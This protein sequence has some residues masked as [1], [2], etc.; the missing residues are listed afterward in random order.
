[1][2]SHIAINNRFCSQKNHTEAFDYH[3]LVKSFYFQDY[4]DVD[5][6]DQYWAQLVSYL[7]SLHTAK[8][9]PIEQT[10]YGGTQTRGN[11]FDNE[12]P[13]LTTLLK[14]LRNIWADYC[15]HIRKVNNSF[16]YVGK[17][18]LQFTGSWSVALKSDGFHTAHIHPMGWIS[19]VIYIDLPEVITADDAK[20][21]WIYFGKPN[22]EPKDK[23][24][25]DHY[26]QPE[27]G[28]TVIFPSY[29]WHGTVP[30]KSDKHRLTIAYD[31]AFVESKS[32]QQ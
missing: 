4:L 21:G 31:A 5:D 2:L 30:F 17:G 19:S 29:M 7:K 10:L 32:D 22:F 18:E 8:N 27:V 23:I 20:Q 12:H 16:H 6:F 1:V 9:N 13:L 24:E 25:P 3:S 11:L 14:A 15:A 26:V 28:K